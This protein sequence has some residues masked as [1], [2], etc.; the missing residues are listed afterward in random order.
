MYNHAR[1]IGVP[2]KVNDDYSMAQAF[3]GDIIVNKGI[4]RV[5]NCHYIGTEPWPK[6]E[7]FQ[8]KVYHAKTGDLLGTVRCRMP[9]EKVHDRTLQ[10]KYLVTDAPDNKLVAE[11]CQDKDRSS[12]ES[13]WFINR[14]G[15]VIF[16]SGGPF[17]CE[18]DV[19]VGGGAALL[20]WI[21]EQ[22]KGNT[23]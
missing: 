3:S 13:M 7:I 11:V 9:K 22:K 16:H 2:T 19:A 21:E 4:L 23:P 5:A 17:F 12:P 1:P 8:F 15:V 6:L 18:V 14:E 20:V 10:G